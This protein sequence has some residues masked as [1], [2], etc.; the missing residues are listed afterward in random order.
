MVRTTLSTPRRQFKKALREHPAK[1]IVVSYDRDSDELLVYFGRESAERPGVGRRVNAGL[2][3]RVD[4]ETGKPLG[5]QIENL[6]SV[7]V[8]KYPDMLVY[9]DFA[10]LRGITVEEVG[11]LRRRY[12]RERPQEFLSPY[13]GLLRTL[14]YA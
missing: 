10:D 4:R 13:R 8:P 11:E 12:A 14:A 5:F 1:D 6:L 7:V 2:Y 9:L 3:L